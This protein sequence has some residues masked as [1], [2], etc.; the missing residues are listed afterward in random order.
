[1]TKNKEGARARGGP[2]KLVNII[3]ARRRGTF[4]CSLPKKLRRVSWSFPSVVFRMALATRSLGYSG[5]PF[6]PILLQPLAS[7]ARSQNLLEPQRLRPFTVTPRSNRDSVLLSNF[8]H[9]G[10]TATHLSPCQGPGSNRLP[11]GH[12]AFALSKACC[13]SSAAAARFAW[14]VLMA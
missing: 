6:N 8:A 3:E 12:S 10:P 9:C 5:G 14:S 1:M 7:L 11:G 4:D 2:E 13:A